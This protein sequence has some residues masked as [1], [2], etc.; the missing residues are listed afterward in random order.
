MIFPQ[1]CAY[2]S[3]MQALVTV[4]NGKANARNADGCRTEAFA[5][6]IRLEGSAR[7]I[8]SKFSSNFVLQSCRYCKLYIARSFDVVVPPL[9]AD[10]RVALIVAAL[11]F[12]WEKSAGLVSRSLVSLARLRPFALFT[13]ITFHRPFLTIQ[14]FSLHQTLRYR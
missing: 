13:F 2:R 3:T 1:V 11:C 4:T 10:C 12:C 6:A 9:P 14:V 5:G 7:R 8:H